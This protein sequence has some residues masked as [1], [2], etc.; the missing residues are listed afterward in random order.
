MKKLFTHLKVY[1]FAATNL[2]KKVFKKEVYQ[3]E[4]E[5]ILFV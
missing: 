4:C 2:A 1:A 5:D 3:P